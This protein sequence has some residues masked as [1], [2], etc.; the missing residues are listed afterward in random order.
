MFSGNEMRENR[1]PKLES[2]NPAKRDEIPNP[3]KQVV[4]AL[5]TK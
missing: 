2:R 4:D 5:W 1:K 3:K